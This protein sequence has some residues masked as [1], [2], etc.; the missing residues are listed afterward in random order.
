MDSMPVGRRHHRL[1]SAIIIALAATAM[2]CGSSPARPSDDPVA[3]VQVGS[4][5]FRIRLAT[6]ALEQ[7]ARAAQAGTGPRIPNGRLVAGTDVNI[8]WSWHLVDVVFAEATIEVCDGRPSDV[9]REGVTY[10]AGRYCPWA[11]TIVAIE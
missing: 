11:A 10:G 3:L 6:P 7:A 8:G 4:E 1:A 9:E 2:S 5:T